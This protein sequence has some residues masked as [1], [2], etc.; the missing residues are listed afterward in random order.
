MSKVIATS[1][2]VALLIGSAA[3]GQLGLI[4]QVQTSDLGLTN[5]VVFNHGQQDGMS[6]QHLCLDLA[7]DTDRACSSCAS[8]SLLG[9]VTQFGEGMGDCGILDLQQAVLGGTNQMQEIGDACGSKAQIQGVSLQAAQGIGKTA[10][11][12]K[13]GAHHT[14]VL[15]ANQNGHN[16]AGGM[17]ERANI[18]AMQDSYLSGEP[19]ATG[20]VGSTMTITTT[21]SQGSF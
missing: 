9:V 1:V 8:Q 13:G 10:G 12:A 19:C 11:Y 20:A 6:D 18:I 17:N 5:D 14:I 3:F 16:A 2:L 15:G 21:Q 7:Q 4:T